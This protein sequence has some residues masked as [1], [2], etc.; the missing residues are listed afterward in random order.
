MSKKANKYEDFNKN[1][2]QR[3]ISEECTESANI[4]GANK[5]RM[6]HIPQLCDGLLPGERRVLYAMMYEKGLRYDKP[7]KKMPSSV[8]AAIEYHPHGDVN[9]IN[10]INKLSQYWKNTQ[11][12]ID[13]HGSNGSEKGDSPAAARYLEAKLT[14]YAHKCY[15][16]DF[17]PDIVDMR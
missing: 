11:T 10:T 16:E 12:L 15:F 5:N 8:G 13:I 9:I 2:I 3:N 6:R 4:Y 14:K 7:Y 17:Y 1:I